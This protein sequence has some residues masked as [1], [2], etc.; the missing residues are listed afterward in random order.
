V[1]NIDRA[2][3]R[4]KKGGLHIRDDIALRRKAGMKFRQGRATRNRE[5][6][7]RDLDLVRESRPEQHRELAG[8]FEGYGRLARHGGG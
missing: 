4:K 7:G 2:D 3:N 6:E 1:E 8:G 5:R